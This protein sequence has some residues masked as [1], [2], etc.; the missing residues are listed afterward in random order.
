MTAKVSE[1]AS[2]KIVAFFVTVVLWLTMLSRRDAVMTREMSLLFLLPNH[3][4]MKNDVPRRV[5]VKLAGPRLALQRY[6]QSES[7][8]TVD[9]TRLPTGRVKVHLSQ[10]NLSLPLGVKVLAIEP[11]EVLVDLKD[12]D[13]SGETS[14]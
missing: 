5:V 12:T 6:V 8:L 3:V 13:T 10:G 7:D 4:S 2:Y 9:L 1:N 14:K 11:E